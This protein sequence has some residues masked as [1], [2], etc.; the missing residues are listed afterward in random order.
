MASRPFRT[1]R[2]L[3]G[4]SS[5]RTATAD[6]LR[7]STLRR[8]ASAAFP[9][10]RVPAPPP[11]RLAPGLGSPGAGAGAPPA[12]PPLAGAGGGRLPL[13]ALRGTAADR[14]GAG[15]WHGSRHVLEFVVGPTAP[16]RALRDGRGAG[17]AAHARRR[18]GEEL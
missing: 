12:L 11:T 8:T 18:L 16:D 3:R 4:S 9:S 10:A 7:F 6:P 13:R 15:P 1:R 17:R 14:A 5:S 2:G